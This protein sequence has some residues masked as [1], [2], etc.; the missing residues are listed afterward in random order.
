MFGTGALAPIPYRWM[1]GPRRRRSEYISLDD[2]P[3][4]RE[5]PA[6]TVDELAQLKKE[7]IDVR[8][9][10]MAAGIEARDNNGAN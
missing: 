2:P 3:P 7:L 6:M 1:R 10:Q 5:K 9:R 8:D 4:T